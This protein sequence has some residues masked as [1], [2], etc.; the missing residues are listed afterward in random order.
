[1]YPV[2][3][4]C[5]EVKPQNRFTVQ[6]FRLQF[7]WVELRVTYVENSITSVLLRMQLYLVKNPMT[8]GFSESKAWESNF[9]FCKFLKMLPRIFSNNFVTEYQKLKLDDSVIFR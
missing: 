4:H 1:M 6:S 8:F 7:Q 2:A 3:Q 5:I 9:C